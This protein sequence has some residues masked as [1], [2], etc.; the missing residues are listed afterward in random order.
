MLGLTY[1]AVGPELVVNKRDQDERTLS[2]RTQVA[3]KVIK[4]S[5]IPVRVVGSQETVTHLGKGKDPGVL[6]EDDDDDSPIKQDF[7]K[8]SPYPKD[9]TDAFSTAKRIVRGVRSLIR[10]STGS[11]KSAAN[12]E[13]ASEV[14][15]TATNGQG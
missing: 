5:S 14:Q 11:R 2:A 9:R 13:V 15:K 6:D 4:Y 8:P 3:E 12:G 10:R 7:D 1:S